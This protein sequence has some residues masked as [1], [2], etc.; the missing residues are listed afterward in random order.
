[1]ET[2]FDALKG[3]PW[4]VYLVFVY[5]LYIGILGLKSRTIS[6]GKVFLLPFIFLLWSV[7]S[8]IRGYQ[9]QS[10]IW[11]WI[12]FLVIGGIAGWGMMQKF[13]VRGD[14]KKLLVRVPGSPMILILV[15]IVFGVKYFFGYMQAIGESGIVFHSLYLVISGLVTGIFAGRA[16]AILRKFSK[17][18]HEKLKKS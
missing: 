1:M 7:W 16:F 9:A 5:V 8:L 13:N 12:L 6:L 3:T 2:I 15:L 4:W 14:H 10:D 11:I 17:T 18:K